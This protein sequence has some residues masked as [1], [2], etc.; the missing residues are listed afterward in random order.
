MGKRIDCEKLMMSDE[1]KPCPFCGGEAQ[2]IEAMGEVWVRCTECN[3]SAAMQN[4]PV[5]ALAKWNT[6]AERTCRVEY[7]EDVRMCSECC[8]YVGPNN[9]YCAH[10][11]AKVVRDDE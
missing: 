6:R 3:A 1:L 7:P 8:Y 2:L 11:G 9:L 4:Y 10:C 5:D